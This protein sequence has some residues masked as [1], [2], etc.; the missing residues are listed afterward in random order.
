MI[1]DEQFD[2]VQRL[3]PYVW[4]RFTP[5]EQDGTQ[6]CIDAGEFYEALLDLL[7]DAKDVPGVPEELLQ[8]AFDHVFD[9]DREEFGLPPKAQ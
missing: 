2:L 8:E 9:E 6:G 4:D 1:V 5:S 3:K 7:W